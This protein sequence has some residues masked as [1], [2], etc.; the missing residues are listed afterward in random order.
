MAKVKIPLGWLECKVCGNPPTHYD[1]N[2]HSRVF[3][4]FFCDT[5]GFR[6]GDPQRTEL[7][8]EEEFRNN[9]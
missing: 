6:K 7:L 8:I 4:G 3:T 1:H 2:S 5:H 9:G